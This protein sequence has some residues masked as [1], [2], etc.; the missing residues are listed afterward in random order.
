MK[1]GLSTWAY[2]WQL[3]EKAPKPLSL[4]DAIDDSHRLGATVFQICDY[5]QI[6]QWSSGE[7]TR[8]AEHAARAGITLE[9]GT[10]GIKP[11]HLQRYLAI[12]AELECSLLRTMINSPDHRPTL[13]EARR[14]VETVLPAFEQQGVAICLETYEQVLTDDNIALVQAINSARFGICLDP[15]NCIASLELPADV[16]AKTASYVLN[17]HVKDFAFSR[18]DGWVGFTLAGR[19]LGEGLLRY[20]D[21]YQQIQP[22]TRG[23]NQIIEHWLPWQGD[24]ET[25]C[26]LEAAWTEHNMRYLLDKQNL[27]NASSTQSKESD[28]VC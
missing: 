23:I 20:D 11:D 6:A 4:F 16:V 19:P 27:I 13:S 14:S 24:S 28:H 5:P 25:T 21:I 22:Q 18:R 2:F 15:A 3:S 1:T 8:L 7:R 10:K 9:L 26:R 12:A 17:W